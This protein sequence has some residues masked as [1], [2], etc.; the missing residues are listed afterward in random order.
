MKERKNES[1]SGRQGRDGPIF[2]LSKSL[3]PTTTNNMDPIL[4]AESFAYRLGLSHGTEGAISYKA[5]DIECREAQRLVS[6]PHV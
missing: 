5:S 3:N 1:W 4:Y 2:E 6:E